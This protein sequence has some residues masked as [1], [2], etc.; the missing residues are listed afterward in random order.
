MQ[1]V[2]MQVVT[3]VDVLADDYGFGLGPDGVYYRINDSEFAP[4]S[5][6]D[7]A[8]DYLDRGVPIPGEFSGVREI[9]QRILG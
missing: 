2:G 6:R 4:I 8:V 9:V 5:A 7:I 1:Y 3:T